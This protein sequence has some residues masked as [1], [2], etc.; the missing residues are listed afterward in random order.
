MLARR[1]LI[2]V[3]IFAIIV[4]IRVSTVAATDVGTIMLKT[5]EEYESVTYQ[6]DYDQ[7]RVVV[8]LTGMNIAVSF[9]LINHIFDEDGREVTGDVL[10]PSLRK[11]SGDNVPFVRK[12]KVGFRIAPNYSIPV[13]Q[14]Y[15]NASDGFG[16]EGDVLLS[17]FGR[18]SLRFSVSRPGIRSA[19]AS[20]TLWAVRSFIIAQYDL[21]SS[22][23]TDQRNFYYA[24]AGLGVITHFYVSSRDQGKPASTV[25]VGVGRWLSDH[26]AYDIT[27][28]GD[29][30]Y[31]DRKGKAPWYHL[32]AGVKYAFIFDAKVGLVAFF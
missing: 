11:Q 29:I 3:Y 10:K 4:L 21:T 27:V 13:G 25:G 9:D 5:G 2:I 28:A 32:M 31:V 23:A 22:R 8:F 20:F 17:W 12:W 18:W 24:Y 7:K 26:F 30:M 6:V 1:T 15:V 14:Y 16:F 19:H